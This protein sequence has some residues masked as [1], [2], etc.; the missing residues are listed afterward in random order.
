MADKTFTEAMNSLQK[1][2][3]RIGSGT[4]TLEESLALFEEGIKEADYCREILDRAEQKII[5]Y[6][7][8][9]PDGEDTENAQ[10]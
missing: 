6:K 10:L 4:V 7:E 3:S 1:A 9:S 5:V 8:G 2:A